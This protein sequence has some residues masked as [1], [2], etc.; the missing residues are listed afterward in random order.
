VC[1]REVCVR[2]REPNPS[3]RAAV[4]AREKESEWVRE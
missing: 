4:P 2:E 1:E 3:E